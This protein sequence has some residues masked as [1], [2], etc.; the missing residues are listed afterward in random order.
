MKGCRI[1]TREA[2]NCEA[3]QRREVYRYPRIEKLR[4]KSTNGAG[5]VTPKL[6]K[7]ESS[8]EWTRNRYPRTAKSENKSRID[9]KLLPKNCKTRKQVKT[10]RINTET[11]K[12]VKT[13]KTPIY[14]LYIKIK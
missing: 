2:Q 6:Q 13:A 9:Q 12:I 11:A 14:S 7:C 3:S 8:Q 1:I 4:S 5:T 10:M